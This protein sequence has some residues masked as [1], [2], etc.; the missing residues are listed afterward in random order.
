MP[1]LK[2]KLPV[3]I[4]IEYLRNVEEHDALE[5][6]RG[7]LTKKTTSAKLHFGTFRLGD[8]YLVEIQESG[9]GYAYAPTLISALTPNDPVRAR[10]KSGSG[11]LYVV[12]TDSSVETMI[13]PLGST[14]A[15]ESELLPSTVPL[16]AVV[17]NPTAHLRKTSFTI[18]AASV[19]LYLISILGQPSTPSI[20]LAAPDAHNLP[21]A[22]WTTEATWPANKVPTTL[23]LDTKLNKYVIEYNTAANH[24]GGTFK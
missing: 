6:A 5:Y 15:V 12:A 14:I 22:Y 1:E 2:N 8:G 7:F 17:H 21:I 20:I 4:H 18:F 3:K 23:K 13:L 10:I 19:A 24:V 16:T 9:L 11:D